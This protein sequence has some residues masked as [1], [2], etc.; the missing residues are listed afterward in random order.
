MKQRAFVLID[1]DEL[2]ADVAVHA[3]YLAARWVYF[4]PPRIVF[5]PSPKP[6]PFLR[7]DSNKV[8]KTPT[9]RP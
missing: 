1:M 7:D 6:P 5:Q 2:D 3:I 8:A 9:R 4:H